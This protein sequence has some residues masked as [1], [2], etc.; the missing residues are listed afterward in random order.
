VPFVQGFSTTTLI[1][2]ASSSEGNGEAGD[3]AS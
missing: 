3:T 1:A 2:K